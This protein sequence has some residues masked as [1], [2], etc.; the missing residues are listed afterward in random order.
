MLTV[1]QYFELI[2]H[3][4]D[5]SHVP[6]AELTDKPDI[7]KLKLGQIIAF[8]NAFRKQYDNDKDNVY[9]FCTAYFND[10][11]E[12]KDISYCLA[13]TTH[14]I[15]ETIAIIE[16]ENAEIVDL[17]TPEEKRAGCDMFDKF[18]TFN[19]LSFVVD[20]LHIS[21][22]IINNEFKTPFEVAL[23]ISYEEVFTCLKMSNTSNIFNNNLRQIYESRNRT[24]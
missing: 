17:T 6:F 2:K 22:M 19:L 10:N 20:R 13:L 23:L 12:D 1:K 16:R 3:G 18:G 15:K 24:T 9:A 11:I 4:V 14:I 5:V 21:P 8:K 7:R